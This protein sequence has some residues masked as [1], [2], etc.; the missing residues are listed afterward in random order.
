MLTILRQVLLPQMSGQICC[1][2]KKRLM[3]EK[4]LTFIQLK[5][6]PSF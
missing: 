5:K 1:R 4:A 3:K 2:I 6:L